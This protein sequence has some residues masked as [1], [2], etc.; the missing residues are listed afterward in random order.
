M[1]QGDDGTI[2]GARAGGTLKEVA[3]MEPQALMAEVVNLDDDTPSSIDDEQ[4]YP[5]AYRTK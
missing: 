4:Q 1:W 5:I 3:P 2:Q